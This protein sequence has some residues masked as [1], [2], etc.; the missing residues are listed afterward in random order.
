MGKPQTSAAHDVMRQTE[1]ARM[2]L[3]AYE[4]ILGND[5]QAKADAVE[6]ETSLVE[7]MT[8]AI[9]RV[10]EIDAL[11]ES[12]DGIIKRTQAR[13]KRLQDQRDL[14]RTSIAVGM[15]VGGMKKLETALGTVSL[16]PAPPKVEITDETLIPAR[17]WERQ[18]PKLNRKALGDALKA[19]E[20]VPGATLGNG[21]ATIAI[22][23]G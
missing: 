10:V 20:D 9:A 1:A 6:G 11:E 8:T 13:R 5:E 19:K 15:E 7:A 22:T 2:L 18:D 16:K 4:D 12:L 14:L 17:F 3:A 21:G 23:L